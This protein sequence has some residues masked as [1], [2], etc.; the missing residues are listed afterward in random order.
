MNHLLPTNQTIILDQASV[1]IEKFLG[2]GAQGEVYQ[3]LVDN[4]PFALKWYVP[5]AASTDQKENLDRLLDMG[6]PSSSFLWPLE[7][8]TSPQ[9]F[10]FLMPLRSPQAKGIVEIYSRRSPVTMH[11]LTTICINIVDAF[12]DLHSKGYCYKDIKSENIFFDPKTGDISICDCD[13]VAIDGE[14][15]QGIIGTMG[16]SAPEIDRGEAQPSI[17]ADLHSLAVLLF[18]ILH[19]HHPLEGMRETAI[20]CLDLP[21]RQQ[22]YGDDPLFIFDPINKENRPDP[23]HHQTVLAHWPIFPSFLKKLFIQA[24]T[25]G[26][27]DPDCRVR[28]TVWKQALA[29]LRDSIVVCQCKANNFYDI[30]HSKVAPHGL[31]WRCK[32]RMPPPVQLQ[33]GKEIIILNPQTTLYPHHVETGKRYDFSKHIGTIV[34]HPK[35]PQKWGLQNLSSTPWSI[36]LPNG[37]SKEV[38]AGKSVGLGNQVIINFGSTEGVLTY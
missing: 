24:F 19:L 23:V 20:K 28:E 4:K 16:Y 34:T 37:I 2:S 15:Y 25:D 6:P 35:K 7:I 8:V 17:R 27:H 10:G 12:S 18:K 5:K 21:A 26:L 30:A 36:T 14:S 3:V 32:Q 13:N 38:P 11:M 31:C 9:G 33:V 1:T 29:K 22:L